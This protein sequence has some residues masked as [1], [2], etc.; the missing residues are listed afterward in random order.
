M[1]PI[2]VLDGF[3][4]RFRDEEADNVDT[5]ILADSYECAPGENAFG[6]TSGLGHTRVTIRR[7]QLAPESAPGVILTYRLANHDPA[8]R[9]VQVEWLARTDL[10]PAWFSLDSG[11]CQDGQDSGAWDAATSTFTAKDDKNPWFAAIRCATAPDSAQVG[12]LFGP[13]ITKGRGVSLS[14][15]YAMTLQGGEERALT[16]YLTG[17]AQTAQQAQERLALLASG[18]DFRAE[19]QAR[20]DALLSQSRLEVPD[21]HFRQVWDWVKVNTDWLIVD[22]APYGRALSAGHARVSLVVR[23]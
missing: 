23:L 22:S 9:R 6:Y 14:V 12:Q 18:K 17:S 4:L 19:K 1:H 3:W 7:E 11:F 21:E 13:Q 15:Q 8:P 20:Y 5:W 2:K 10:Y 16:F